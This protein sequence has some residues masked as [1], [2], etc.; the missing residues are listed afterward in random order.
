[1]NKNAQKKEV[2]VKNKSTKELPE[3]KDSSS[4]PTLPQDH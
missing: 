3:C 1:M 4:Q 2:D